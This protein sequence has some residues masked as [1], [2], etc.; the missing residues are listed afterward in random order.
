MSTP[1]TIAI[2]DDMPV[3]I[4]DVLAKRYSVDAYS[5]KTNCSQHCAYIFDCRGKVIDSPKLA[6]VPEQYIVYALIDEGSYL[7]TEIT[8][9]N[10]RVE[11]VTEADL[12]S[13]ILGLKIASRFKTSEIL[14][15]KN[16]K[17]KSIPE[18]YAFE[19][20]EAVMQYSAD[21][22][23]VKNL[24]NSFEMVSDQFANT[25][26]KDKKDIIG[27][28]YL[29]IGI[30]K[31]LVY[32]DPEKNL[33]GIWVEDSKVVASGKPSL[34]ELLTIHESDTELV[35]EQVARI[36]IK[37][38]EGDVRAILVCITQEIT[39][40]Y[41][42]K[43]SAAATHRRNI[44]TSPILMKMD[45][46]NR[47]AKRRAK[48]AQSVVETKNLF[49]ATSSHDLRQPL[50]AMG[51]FI[52]S[53]DR[54]IKDAE[55]LAIIAKLKHSAMDLNKLLTSLLDISKLDA[56]AVPINETHFSINTLFQSIRNEFEVEALR[57]SIVLN[58]EKNDTVIYTDSLLLSRVLKS[59]V[60]N[61]IKYTKKGSV[62][63][64]TQIYGDKLELKIIDTG[65]GI[66]QHAHES[67][68]LEYFQI[69]ED[70]S[71]DNIGQ[72][73]GLSIVKRLVEL[74]NLNLKLKSEI[75][76]GT[77]FSLKVPLG[78][79]SKNEL[80]ESI[81]HQQSD[82]SSYKIMVIDDNAMVLDSMATILT[83]FNC[84]TYPALGVG[85]AIEIID[86]L[87][88]LPDLLVVDYQ[89]AAGV[90]GNTAIKAIRKHAKT[91]IP[92]IIVTGFLNSELSALADSWAH[93]ILSKPVAP[94]ELLNAITNT[95]KNKPEAEPK[96]VERLLH[97]IEDV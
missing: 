55:Q 48:A 26:S 83:S 38:K 96:P 58:V 27:K 19:I 16:T 71:L 34:S 11:L 5:C 56:Q 32:G 82:L 6:D 29:E 23:V 95:I 13:D 53:L 36:P 68:F 70:D 69:Q 17:K 50:H 7:P 46:E 73:L 21:W 85:E 18:E 47:R 30:A 84:D 52:E 15:A 92:A 60:N 76:K 28:N 93:P 62:S 81:N 31:N 1:T 44:S 88:Q 61:A 59:L 77:E 86:E 65:K 63:V 87:E 74:L 3:T 78:S 9:H 8:E 37:N 12:D 72:G 2:S 75:N 90:T 49:I 35:K 40:K 22:M 10:A 89:L 4:R 20:L 25:F 57:K 33:D 91:E 45:D 64:E 41:I 39:R 97:A 24:E 42:D 66:P 43:E 54:K 67:I 79:W 51:L 14:K 94:A 80:P